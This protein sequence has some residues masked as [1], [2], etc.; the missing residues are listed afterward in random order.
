MILLMA[1]ILSCCSTQDKSGSDHFNGKTYY[2]INEDSGH[3]F[4]GMIKWLWMPMK[5][6]WQRH[7][8]ITGCL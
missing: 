4:T 5:K 1:G 3:T 8:K 7:L 6:T 2:N